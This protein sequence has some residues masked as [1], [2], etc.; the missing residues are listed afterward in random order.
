M[1]RRMLLE[2][3][4]L[5]IDIMRNIPLMTLLAVAAASSMLEINCMLKGCMA[6]WRQNESVGCPVGLYECHQKQRMLA[7]QNYVRKELCRGRV[8][9]MYSE[10]MPNGRFILCLVAYVA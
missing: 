5:Y 2:S 6:V 10:V 9:R 7:P 4:L 8:A 3:V 1:L